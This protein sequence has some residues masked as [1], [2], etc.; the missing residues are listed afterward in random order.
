MSLRVPPRPLRLP[1]PPSDTG[2]S[3]A[4][5]TAGLTTAQ[6]GPL[7]PIAR[8]PRRDAGARLAPRAGPSV[9]PVC[10]VESAAPTRDEHGRDASCAEDHRPR[11]RREFIHQYISS[12]PFGPDTPRRRREAASGGMT[13]SRD[14]KRVRVTELRRSAPRRARTSHRRHPGPVVWRPPPRI[15]SAPPRHT[16][17]PHSAVPTT[18]AHRVP[19]RGSPLHRA[20]AHAQPAAATDVAVAAPPWR[21]APRVRRA[22]TDRERDASIAPDRATQTRRDRSLHRTVRGRG[23]HAGFTSGLATR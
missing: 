6:W 13:A 4:E 15:D 5:S 3:G 23:V 2:L 19:P 16:P 8:A 1:S 9:R 11:G 18:R 12:G 17:N 7:T 10:S 20:L 22:G 21:R 14:R